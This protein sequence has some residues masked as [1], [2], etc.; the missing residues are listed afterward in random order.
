MPN[1]QRIAASFA[2]FNYT[3]SSRPDQLCVRVGETMTKHKS[4]PAVLTLIVYLFM[5]SAPAALADDQCLIKPNAPAP[6]GEHWYYR[7]DRVNKR[8]CW[9]LRKA[10]LPVRKATPQTKQHSTLQA[11]TPPGQSVQP[12]LAEKNATPAAPPDAYFP[13]KAEPVRWVDATDLSIL[14]RIAPTARSALPQDANAESDKSLAGSHVPTSAIRTERPADVHVTADAVDT[15][16]PADGHARPQSN[17]AATKPAATKLA[18]PM[19]VKSL[20]TETHLLALFMLLFAALAIT[21]PLLHYVERRRA[22]EAANFRP[23]QWARVVALNAPT[24]RIRVPL[25]L[26]SKADVKHLPAA[27]PHAPPD[28]TERLAQALQQ[29]AD[30]LRAQPELAPGTVSHQAR[31]PPSRDDVMQGQRAAGTA[32]TKAFANGD[33]AAARLSGATHNTTTTRPW[34]AP[35]ESHLAEDG[36]A[37]QTAGNSVSAVAAAEASSDQYPSK[38]RLVRHR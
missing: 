5:S 26:A 9:Y 22:R 1:L 14:P 10:G 27:L 35:G 8:R 30:R 36:Y 4:L 33:T 16:S 20:A 28:H 25:P 34:R 18:A 6:H 23:P 15:A 37:R 2:L 19:P 29:L 24:P 21:G 13:N 17:P 38:L 31:R 32:P 11:H 7:T 12:S 3:C